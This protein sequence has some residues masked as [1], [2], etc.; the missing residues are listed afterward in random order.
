VNNP[1]AGGAKAS[2]HRITSLQSD[3]R[4]ESEEVETLFCSEIGSFGFHCVLWRRRISDSANF[5]TSFADNSSFN[6]EL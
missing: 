3:L 6:R 5:I 2:A 4:D 1:V